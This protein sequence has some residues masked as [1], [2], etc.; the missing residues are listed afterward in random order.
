[1]KSHKV[2]LIIRDGW[3]HGEHN[4]GNAISNANVPNH[5]FYKQNYPHSIIRCTG[6]A[7]GNPEGVQGGSEV[8]HLTIGAGRIVWQPYE[9]INQKIK[10]EE[11]YNNPALLGAIEH[12]KKNNSNLHL[13]G[14]FSSEGVHADFRHMLAIL[15]LCKK[16]GFNRVYIHLTLDGRDMPEKSAMPM[17]EETEAKIKELGF[18]KIASVCGRYYAMDR[19]MNWDRTRKSYD[20]MVDGKGFSAKSAKQAIE[21]AYARGDKTDYYVQPVVIVDETDKPIGLLKDNDAMIWYNFR[22]DRAKQITAMI[23]G[24]DMC[25]ELP[26]HK[27]K[28]HYV[29]FSRYNAEWDLPIAFPQE[30]IT[31]NL[32]EVVSNNGLKQLRIAET[33]KY[34]HVTFFFNSQIEQPYKGE[35]RI[36]VGSPKVSSYD[37]KPEMSAYELTDKLIPEIGKHD[38]IVANYANP[39]LVGHSGVFNAV[40]KAVEVVDECVGKVIKQALEKDYVV[41]LMADHGNADHMLYDNNEPDPSHG[42]NPVLFHLISND[43]ELKNI[44]LKDGGM[45]DVAPTVLKLL[46]LK[47]PEEMNGKSLF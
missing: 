41:L 30:I 28:I 1:M 11:F 15:D 2:I 29:C 44:K 4:K 46:G 39:D 8:G 34:A 32:G 21:D 36:L 47:K 20:L 3:G 31:N 12:C 23:C 38:F 25:N 6:N 24:F 40:V 42:F 37:Q 18:G 9:L 10:N 7:V 27:V 43:N 35:E 33:E 22:S 45:R 26:E 17:V 13:N 19:D 5:E 16:Q 14:L